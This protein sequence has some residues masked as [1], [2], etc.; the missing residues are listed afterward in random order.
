M[1]SR[2][3]DF[4]GQGDRSEPCRDDFSNE[5]INSRSFDSGRSPR[6]TVIS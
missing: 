6:M 5:K 4:C 1:T 3:L 2:G